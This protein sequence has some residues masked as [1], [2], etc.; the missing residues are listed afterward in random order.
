MNPPPYQKNT[1]LKDTKD[2]LEGSIRVSDHVSKDQD[3]SAVV[4]VSHNLNE[5]RDP[6]ATSD[7]LAWRNSESPLRGRGGD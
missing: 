7:R 6:R 4:V 5:K 2:P 1:R 3:I